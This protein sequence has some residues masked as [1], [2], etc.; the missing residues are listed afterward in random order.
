MNSGPKSRR[1]FKEN[2]AEGEPETKID[3]SGMRNPRT[4]KASGLDEN[5]EGSG[6][7][8]KNSEKLNEV[9]RDSEE[10]KQKL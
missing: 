9:Q 5:S 7:L 8:P 10:T 4:R 2:K 6:N 1:A 3:S